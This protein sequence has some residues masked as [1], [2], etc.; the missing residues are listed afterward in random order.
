[1]YQLEALVMTEPARDRWVEM[2]PA[3]RAAVERSFLSLLENSNDTIVVRLVEVTN[4]YE[5]GFRTY[6]VMLV[7]SS[8]CFL[9]LATYEDHSMVVMDIIIKG[10]VCLLSH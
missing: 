9:A 7:E 6:E 2:T 4:R 5:Q 10:D 1:M 3:E 8:A